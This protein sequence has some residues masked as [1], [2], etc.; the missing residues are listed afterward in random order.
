MKR[1][2]V[3]VAVLAVGLTAAACSSSTTAGGTAASGGS[4]S[5]A[6]SPIT[7]AFPAPITSGNSTAAGQMV[8]SAKLAV[9]DINKEGGAGGHQLVLKVYDDQGTADGATQ[10]VQRAITQDGAKVIVGAYSTAE[11]IAVR[12]VAEREGVVYIGVSAVGPQVTQGAKYTFR[13]TINQADYSPPMARVIKNLGL[14]KPAILAD[15][16]PVGSML[17]AGLVAQLKSLGITPFSPVSYT[18][19]S[20]DVTAPVSTVVREKPDSVIV[21]A[22][23]A[24][25]EGLVVKTLAEQGLKVPVVGFGSL[26]AGDALKIGGAAYS[27]MPGVYTVQNVDPNNA[28]YQKFLKEYA[29]AY[30]GNAATLATTLNEQAADTYTAFMAL[31]LGLDADKG[32]AS[33]DALAAALHTISYTDPVGGKDGSVVSFKGSQDGFHDSLAVFKLGSDDEVTPDPALNK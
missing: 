1:S 13:T 27:Q 2:I 23:L 28:Q 7:V 31:K 24:S 12:T 6:G 19:G 16:G 26:V 21:I 33:G 32:D 8:N 15:T 20:T 10:V 17:P 11:S 5:A 18:L 4:S 3:S 29:A 25:D 22:S 9:A 14:S 30:D